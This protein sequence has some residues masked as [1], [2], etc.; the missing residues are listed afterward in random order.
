MKIN[1]TNSE[2]AF[3]ISY[4]NLM[5]TLF[6]AFLLVISGV[7]VKYLLSQKEMAS[8]NES[9]IKSLENSKDEK[10]KNL[11]YERLNAVL[12]A[13]L[14]KMHSLNSELTN[15]NKVLNDE[16]NGLKNNITK[17]NEQN[18]GANKSILSLQDKNDDLNSSLSAL[19]TKISSLNNQL[20]ANKKSLNDANST[21]EQIIANLQSQLKDKINDINSLSK[22]LN[23]T[24]EQF[25]K[26]TEIRGKIITAL[27]EKL[28]D[29]AD[30]DPK[31]GVLRLSSSILFDR[32]KFELKD[33]YKDE[34]KSTLD[35]YFDVLL[36]DTSINKYIE[37]IVIE[38]FTDS[39]GT[40]LRNLEL[41]QKRAYSVMDFINSYNKDK[42]LRQLLIASGRSYNNLIMKDGVE[43]K[44]ASRR[45]EIKFNISNKETIERI[46]KF[47]NKK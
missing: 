28:G 5:A 21:N 11:S 33:A 41:S 43:D 31:T 45:I 9:I 4:A 18:T 44:E 8:K 22:D 16:L 13:E 29:D 38:G 3:W 17:L 10:G 37:Q 24:K 32:A 15:K 30:I 40:Y 26:L 47:L 42:K 39:D 36:N 6:F 46:E 20:E 34:L 35:K 2:K 7:V 27:K 19:Q 25:K 12:K 23:S 14:A 1:K